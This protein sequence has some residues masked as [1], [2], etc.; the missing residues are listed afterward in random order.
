MDNRILEFDRLRGVAILGVL[1]IHVSVH[2]RTYTDISDGWHMWYW[3]L[4]LSGRIGVPAFLVISGYFLT[5]SEREG[6][7]TWPTVMARVL[8]IVPPY[9]IWS[10]VYFILTYPYLFSDQ[11]TSRNILL[12]FIEKL[13]LGNVTWQLYFIVLV[14]QYYLLSACGFCRSGE[15][16]FK[17]VT[18]SLLLQFI[19]V[20]LCYYDSVVERLD[21]P[22]VSEVLY[23][24]MSYR[25]S[26][27]PVYIGYFLLGRWLGKNYLQVLNLC[28][29][30]RLQLSV[31]WVLSVFYVV[32]ETLA[33]RV[34]NEERIMLPPDWLISVNI[35]ILLSLSL[36]IPWLRG[37]Q[38]KQC[39]Q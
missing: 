39:F 17:L 25:L 11:E 22:F 24:F 34:T 8:R 14:I 15:V 36:I 3:F 18:F 21:S 28:Y 13:L 27:F 33:L 6:R 19:Y 9:L 10:T 20:L 4:C 35:Y 2:S 32:F 26:T 16:G 5:V 1:L 37:L 29:A 23:Y 31:L 7:E 30:R 12:I 38:K